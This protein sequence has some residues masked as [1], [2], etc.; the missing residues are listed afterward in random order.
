MHLTILKTVTFKRL[1]HYP[2]Q[3]N[4]PIN[5][6]HLK[7]LHLFALKNPIYTNSYEKNISRIDCKVYEGDINEFWLD[8][9]K[10]DSSLQPFYPTWILSAYIKTLLAKILNYTE[11]IDVGSGDGRIAYCGKI[12]DLES[13]GIEIDQKLVELQKSISHSTG[14]DFNPKCANAIEFD[15]SSLNLK[16]PAFFIGGLAQM[17]GDILAQGVIEKINSNCQS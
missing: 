17:G 5:E 16:Q 8:S 13:H 9:I 14:I 12:L 15:Y 11:I 1:F 10:H 4:F 7:L 6:K 2:S 3:K